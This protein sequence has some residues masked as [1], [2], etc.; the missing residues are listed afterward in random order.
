MS[1]V[2]FQDDLS[3]LFNYGLHLATRT[4]YMG[5]SARYSQT[6]SDTDFT[7]AETI[8][9]SIHLL[10]GLSGEPI[11][12]IMNN[13]GG[14][15]DH[16]SAIWDAIAQS[17]CDVSMTVRGNACSMGSVLLQ[18]A[19]W[20]IM[21]PTSIYMMHYDDGDSSNASQAKEDK[22]DEQRYNRWMEDMYL[23]RIR[24]KK[25]RFSRPALQKLLSVNSYFTATK[26][27]EF[28]LIDEIG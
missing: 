20:R 11:H 1:L 5:R 8:I 25:P 2:T 17:R 22:A 4:I 6:E 13:T 26:A 3:N 27:L 18:A 14:D 9:K 15:P 7:M 10:S 24:V 28:G 21:G 16:G 12:I 23:E 19:D